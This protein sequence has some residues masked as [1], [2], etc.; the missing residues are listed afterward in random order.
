LV[1][2][3]SAAGETR[4][5]NLNW[6]ATDFLVT[7]LNAAPDL[8]AFSEELSSWT[9][10]FAAATEHNLTGTSRPDLLVGT[11]GVDYLYGRDG[12]DILLGKG[13]D[14][15]LSGGAGADTYVFGKGSGQDTVYNH[16]GEA[17]GTHADTIL[18][19]EG[20]AS[21]DV[22]LT[23]QYED[24]IISLNGSADSLR[25]QNY[26]NTDGESSYVVENL[27]FADGMVWDVATVKTK[28]L[29]ATYLFTPPL[30]TPAARPPRATHRGP[31]VQD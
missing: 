7:Q 9:V 28:V 20:I 27:K 2:F 12:N 5:K 24:L 23:R 16:D 21:T 17:I 1:E 31:E 18:L 30:K 14:D 26:F 13:G 19:S 8:G 10:R 11:A 22:T 29:T 3:L 25:V 6:N 4:L 15:Y